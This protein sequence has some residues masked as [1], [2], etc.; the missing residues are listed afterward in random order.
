MFSLVNKALD[1]DQDQS[2]IFVEISAEVRVKR[3]S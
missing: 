1:T 3:R 2:F